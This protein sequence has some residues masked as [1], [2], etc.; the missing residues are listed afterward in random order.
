MQLTQN[1]SKDANN[2]GNI[3]SNYVITRY[4]TTIIRI[5]TN[6]LSSS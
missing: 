6:I 5:F 4:I 3:T 2:S 1:I